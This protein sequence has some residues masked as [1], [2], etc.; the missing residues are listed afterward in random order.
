MPMLSSSQSNNGL[1]LGSNGSHI[2]EINS[3]YFYEVRKR[4]RNVYDIKYSFVMNTINYSTNY[5]HLCCGN[6]SL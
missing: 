3:F 1:N 2:E 4:I 6:V 5:F